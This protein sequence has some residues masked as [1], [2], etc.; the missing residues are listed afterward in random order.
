MKIA[1][2]YHATVV[3][4]AGC[5]KAPGYMGL[6]IDTLASSCLELY[7]IVHQAPAIERG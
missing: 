6:F 2:Y 1:F 4:D 7:Y 3:F 5:V